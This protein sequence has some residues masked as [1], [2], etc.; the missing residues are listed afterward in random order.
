[1]G[2]EP[3]RGGLESDAVDEQVDDGGVG[4]EGDRESGSRGAEPELLSAD[5][6]VARGGNDPGYFYGQADVVA[7]G[8]R[9]GG[10]GG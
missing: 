8:H 9:C 2:G 10:D 4:P 1:V 5:G 6:E 7:D 3:G